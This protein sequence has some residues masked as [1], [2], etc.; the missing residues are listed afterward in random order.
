MTTTTQGQGID[1]FFTL[2]QGL[3]ARVFEEQRDLFLQVAERMVQTIRGNGRI[4]VFGTGHSHMMVE[5][6][7]YR[8][9]GLA[10]AV[11]ILV[12][13]LMLHGNPDLGSQLE[14]APGLA[15]IYLDPYQPHAGEMLFVY[16]NSGVNRLPVEMALE[17]RSRGLTVVAVCSLAYARVAPLSGLGKR[18][19]EVVDYVIDNGGVPGDALLPIEGYDCCVAPSSTIMGAMIWNAL[20]AEVT[21]QLASA[22]EQ[23]PVFVSFNVAGSAEHNQAV[24]AKWGQVNPHMKGWM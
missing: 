24:L 18:L 13:D 22:G 14:R 3:Q 4:F 21:F 19:D 2:I 5:E 6:T 20:V 15:H 10:A 1:R 9:G 12:N 7:F 16:S 8:A 17:A 11:P 23:L